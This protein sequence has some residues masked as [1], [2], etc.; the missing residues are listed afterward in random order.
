M[1]STLHTTIKD[2][3]PNLEKEPYLLARQ[4]N[5]TSNPVCSDSCMMHVVEQKD[6]SLKRV[7][8]TAALYAMLPSKAEVGE[9]L[10]TFGDILWPNM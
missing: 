7:E 9:F 3:F 10:E 8:D 2:I 4:T 6:D 5:T 1:A